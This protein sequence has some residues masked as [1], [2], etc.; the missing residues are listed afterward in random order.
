M[1]SLSPSSISLS[2]FLCVTQRVYLT[3]SRI[4]SVSRLD[5]PCLLMQQ[6]AA[7]TED[8]RTHAHT[9]THVDCCLKKLQN[10]FIFF[11]KCFSLS[12]YL[13]RTH[14]ALFLARL[15][16]A[17]R[18]VHFLCAAN[19]EGEEKETNNSRKH[20]RKKYAQNN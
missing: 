4:R 13:A 11:F 8:T 7:A 12:R 19:A 2:H 18:G 1:H 15:L 5:S 6:A 10:I 14:A 9:H 3:S 17:K 20:T 16:Y